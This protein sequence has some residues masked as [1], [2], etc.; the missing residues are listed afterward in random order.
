MASAISAAGPS[1]CFI[2]PGDSIYSPDINWK[3]IK[4]YYGLSDE[5]NLKSISSLTELD[6][7]KIS[8][9][10]KHI[11][12]YLY[13]LKRL[14]M[15][16]DADDI[17]YTRNQSVTYLLIRSIAYVPKTKRPII[18]AELHNE[19][20]SLSNTKSYELIDGIVVI[21]K[22]LKKHIV[23]KYPISPEN[24]L[25][26][27]DGVDIQSYQTD[28]TQMNARKELGLPVDKNIVMYTGNLYERKGVQYLIE[29]ADEINGEIHIVGGDREDAEWF[30]SSSQSMTNIH[31]EGFVH[32]SIVHKYQISS[33][34]LIAP[35]TSRARM[36]SP[37]KIFE[38]MAAGRPIVA[39]RIPTI[40]EVLSDGENAILVEPEDARSIAKS[41]NE[42]LNNSERSQSI[43]KKAKTDAR[44]YTW[45]SRARSV[46]EFANNLS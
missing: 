32:P 3:N 33:D 1:V 34:I 17:I 36:P 38:Y 7:P 42:V 12:V 31:F 4:E 30:D 11:T 23:E 21:T 27:H 25:I 10:S 37:L 6:I 9:I 40:E 44:K 19:Q 28:L 46:I 26:A 43:S 39:S 14:I 13:I 22:I 18:I 8:P 15:Q 20:E 24:C 45:E 2:H 5:F 35:Y 41:V 29:A 16:M